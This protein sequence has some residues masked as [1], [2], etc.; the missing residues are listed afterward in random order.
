MRSVDWRVRSAVFLGR[1]PD[2]VF[3]QVRGVVG[4]IAGITP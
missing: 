2:A 1:M 4:M 3:A